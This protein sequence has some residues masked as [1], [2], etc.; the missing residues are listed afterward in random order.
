L[1]RTIVATSANDFHRLQSA[2][3]HL[4]RTGDAT[5]FQS[6]SWNRLAASVFAEREQP[7]V[8][9]AESDSGMAII[10]A[11]ISLRNQG[12]TFLGEALFDYRDFLRAGDGGVV[13][14]AW[15]RIAELGLPVRIC[16]LRDET[17]SRAWSS[18][19]PQ[20]FCNAPAIAAGQISADDFAAR[21]RRLGWHSRRMLREGAVLRRYSGVNSDLVRW[22]YEQ[23]ARQFDGDANNLFSDR[24]RI[25]FMV[26]MA[27]LQPQACD[28][29]TME[30]EGGTVAARVTLL[31]ERTRR[32][33]TVYHDAKWGHHSPGTVLLYEVTRKTLA[34]GLGCDYMTGE[35]PFKQ[36]LAT[37]AVPLFRAH[38]SA[39]ELAEICGC[40]I[41]TALPQSAA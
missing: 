38:A 33:Y 30:A 8:V 24:A 7:Y 31:D 36:R 29:F 1:L 4:Q 6:F 26:C 39:A 10:P 5:I 41:I 9:L 11:A 40:E 3:E 28:I 22:I 18:F 27:R 2:W 32:F 13:G 16:G 34:E 37:C 15:A 21:H 19:H 25:D 14:A 20:F 12:V 23:K 17:V 35:Q